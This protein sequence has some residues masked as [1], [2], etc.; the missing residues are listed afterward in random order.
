MHCANRRPSCKKYDFNVPPITPN[1]LAVARSSS[2][3]SCKL[4]RV[5]DALNAN[6]VMNTGS[7]GSNFVCFRRVRVTDD[8]A[9]GAVAERSIVST[10]VSSIAS[11][12]VILCRRYRV[13]VGRTRDAHVPSWS[14]RTR[15]LLVRHPSTC[16]TRGSR[17]HRRWCGARVSQSSSL[18]GASRARAL[19]WRARTR[20]TSLLL[21]LL[22]GLIEGS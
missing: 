15:A 22:G 7:L 14:G 20:R 17:T 21:G 18:G 13:V 19:Q 1:N 6:C 3:A 4:S 10:R 5:A 11:R 9:R 8:G 12:V 2:C 16:R